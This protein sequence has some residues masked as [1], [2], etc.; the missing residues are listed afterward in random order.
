MSSRGSFILCLLLL[1]PLIVVG[2]VSITSTPPRSSPAVFQAG[3]NITLTCSSTAN[4]YSWTSSFSE[5]AVTT[6]NI[7]GLFL[8][9]ANTGD[10]VCSSG[11]NTGTYTISVQ[12][13]TVWYNN[14]PPG[15]LLPNNTAI[16]VYEDVS[17]VKC[18][19]GDTS[20]NN[21]ATLIVTPTG[22]NQPL[23]FTN[24][25]AGYLR[26]NGQTS[27]NSVTNGVYTCQYTNSSGGI[28][29]TSFAVFPRSREPSSGSSNTSK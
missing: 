1:T 12:G 10:H 24:R 5:S 19:T 21:D 26:K 4:T 7:T 29:Y 15:R 2:N 22:S 18:Y 13:T 9:G 8:H 16:S 28:S 27:I 6:S 11:G 25:E 23:T 14:P 20:T 17:E 3:E